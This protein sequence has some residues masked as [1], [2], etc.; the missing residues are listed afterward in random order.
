MKQVI[1]SVLVLGPLLNFLAD[2]CGRVP[3]APNH[4]V[5]NPMPNNPTINQNYFLFENRTYECYLEEKNKTACLNGGACFALIIQGER[6][7]YCHCL[8]DYTGLRCQ[9]LNLDIITPPTDQTVMAKAG[10]AAFITVLVA[11]IFF[12]FFV[13]RG[14]NQPGRCKK[15][16]QWKANRPASSQQTER[17][18]DYVKVHI[19]SVSSQ[20]DDD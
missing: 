13:L 8:K 20:Q 15:C 7:A 11:V 9:E 10:I 19:G 3:A 14:G 12:L 17:S 6:S 4:T 16:R 5:T 2:G 1:M 18:K